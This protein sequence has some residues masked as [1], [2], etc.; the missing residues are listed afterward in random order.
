MQVLRRTATWLLAAAA[1]GAC[2]PAARADVYD[3]NPAAASRGSN[4]LWVFARRTTDGSILES[5]F[6]GTGWTPFTS[7]GGDT[8]SGPAAAAYGP[9]IEVF[10]RGEDGA[11][12]TDVL[13][14][15]AWTGWSS[16]GGYFTSGP[17]AIARRGTTVLDV[18]GRGGDNSIYLSTYVPGT[19]WSAWGDLGGNLTS[20]PALD[21]H[22]DGI[23]DV[24]AR[25]VDGTMQQQ[26]WNGSQWLG[27]GS[28]GGGILGAPT[29]VNKQ[30]HDL[31]IYVR[32]GANVLY[33][34]HWDSVNGWGAYTAIDSTPLGSS[35]AA[36]SDQAGREVLFMRRGD[37]LYQKTWDASAG[38]SG[39]N[40]FASI[41][42]PAP[43]P[44]PVAQD[45][46]VGLVAGLRCT[47][48]GGRL[49]VSISIHKPKGKARARV[50]RIVFFTRGKARDVRVDRKRPFSVRIRINAP[51]GKTGRVFARVYFRRSKH[52]KLHHKTVSR[53]YTVCA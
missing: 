16:L 11:I 32:G 37:V 36:V 21:S 39:W 44:V 20:A 7:L 26:S 40:V 23:L 4:D 6:T 25:G 31:D 1:L 53:R 8:T 27:W 34:R 5:H 45:G 42:V 46:E 15:G 48:P 52:G 18:A 2:A 10:A 13:V 29:A 35:V 3:D 9:N 38:W 14:N 19:G 50:Q 22:S 12:W 28:D 30:P 47:P 51:A 41:A 17:A 33:Q 43:V 24:F 49:R